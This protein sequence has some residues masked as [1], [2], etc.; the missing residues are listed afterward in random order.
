MANNKILMVII[1]CVLTKNGTRV[2]SFFYVIELQLIWSQS[3]IPQSLRECYSNNPISNSSLPMNLRVLVDILRKL[4]K[5]SDSNVD[6]RTM[7]SSIL[8]RF[9][10]DGIE[11]HKEVQSANGVLPFAATGMQRVRNSLMEDLVPGNANILPAHVLSLEER[12]TLHRIISNTI[13]K[14]DDMN[15]PRFDNTTSLRSCPR[16]EG[17]LLTSYGTVAPGILIGAIA[18]SLQHQNVSIKQLVAS[19]EAHLLEET[20]TDNKYNWKYDEEEIDFVLPRSEMIHEPS[21]WYNQLITS[22]AELDNIWLTTIAGELAEIVLFQGPLLGN[23]MTLGAMGFWEYH[24]STQFPNIYYLVNEKEYF[25]A[26]RA[27]LMGGIDGMI[28]A[29]NLQTWLND[30]YSLRLSQIFSMYYSYDGIT[31]SAKLRACEREH[32][33]SHAIPKTDLREQT[34][35]TAQMLA[36]RKSIAYITPE[37]LERMV[38]VATKKFYTYTENHL[39]SE[40][41]CHPTYEPQVE[42]LVVLDGGWSEEFAKNFLATLLEDLDVSMYGSRM[43]VIHGTSGEWLLNVTN[44]PSIAYQELNNFLSASWSPKLNFT[45]VLETVSA[46]LNEVWKRNQEYARIGD[47]GQVVILLT[48]LGSMSNDEQQSAI[49]SLR[50]IKHNHPDVHFIY[51]VSRYNENLF[52]SFVL[53]NEDH[54]ISTNNIKLISHYAFEIP[55][56]L[57]SITP[58]NSNDSRNLQFEDYVSPSKT[59]TYRIHKHWTRNLQKLSIHTFNYGTMQ[60]CLWIRHES[61]D[62]KTVN[63]TKL[64]GYEEIALTNDVKCNDGSSCPDVYLSLGNI[65]SLYRCV[66]IDCKTPDQVRVILRIKTNQANFV[67]PNMKT[68]SLCIFFVLYFLG[69]ISA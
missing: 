14:P 24:W 39:S 19:L 34:Y 1:Y 69:R 23:N 26:T 57:R 46:H 33:L 22:N 56:T 30:L 21:M 4:E 32:M 28:I 11:Y 41:S 27:E 45:R 68:I 55:R 49:T 8:H 12:C 50:E 65:T 51:Y 40:S 54:M 31:F 10:F 44:S 36:H 2:S 3:A 61:G 13:L 53:S 16:E 59:V 67:G 9:K 43:G 20:T 7:T 18:A 15:C 6:M 25:E 47:L 52:K 58:L 37:A 66:E 29:K 35:A 64:T 63:C 48:P 62:L 17:V 60:A 38:N 5:H 42:A